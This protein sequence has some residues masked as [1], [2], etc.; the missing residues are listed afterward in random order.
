MSSSAPD[1]VANTQGFQDLPAV[2]FIGLGAMGLPMARRLVAAGYPVTVYDLSA[3]AVQILTAAGARSADCARTVAA[4]SD[5]VIT[6]LPDSPQVQAAMAGGD[7][8]LAGLRPDALVVDMST[9]SP[10]VSREVGSAVADAGGRFIDAP[11]GRTS[12]H[13]EDGDLLIMVGGATKD[14]DAALPVLEHFGTTSSVAVRSEPV[15]R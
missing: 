5:V 13:A 10:A 2:G 15:R 7:G 3:A 4:A 12:R 9:I 11:V 14:V 8:V 6:M 1:N